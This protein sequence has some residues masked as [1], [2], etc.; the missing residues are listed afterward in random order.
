MGEQ[1]NIAPA[2][3]LGVESV[4]DDPNSSDS[5]SG[6]RS[7]R[8]FG[9][10]QEN[11]KDIESDHEDEGKLKRNLKNRHLQMIAIGSFSRP[12][13]QVHYGTDW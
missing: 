2:N 13:L 5:N 11:G 7:R 4:V 12:L 8:R 3:K 10:A 1:D 9:S 6:L